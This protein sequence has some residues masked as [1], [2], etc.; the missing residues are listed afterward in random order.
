HFWKTS[1]NNLP[2]I[3]VRDN[4]SVNSSLLATYNVRDLPTAFIINREGDIVARVE[5]L[6]KLT[7]EL[8]KVL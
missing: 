2:W 1:A 7:E 8:I 5:D 4:R 6:S 3:T